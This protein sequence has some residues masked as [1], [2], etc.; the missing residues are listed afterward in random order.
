M[1]FAPKKAQFDFR[2]GK[3]VGAHNGMVGIGPDEAIG[4][5][6]QLKDFECASVGVNKPDKRHV[7]AR[8]HFAFR[9]AV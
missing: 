4:Q 9:A 8:V 5:S 1:L 2:R 7:L 3:R 6:V